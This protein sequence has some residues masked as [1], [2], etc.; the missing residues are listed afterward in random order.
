MK[1]LIVILLYF[2]SAQSLAAISW[3]RIIL[4]NG[5]YILMGF[6]PEDLK[7]A[8][9]LN[10]FIEG[11]GRPGV[12]LD[13]AQKIGGNSVYIGRPCQYFNLKTQNACSKEIWTSHRYSADVVD[14]MDRAI[15]VLKI[16]YKA[17]HVRLVGFSG[18]GAIASIIASKRSDV[19][20]L[21]TVAGNL[22]HK[23]WTDFNHSPPL[24]GSLNPIDFTAKLKNVPQ[25]HLIGD[26]DD[27]VPS[28]VLTSYLARLKQLDNVHIYVVPGADHTCCWSV[29]LA[30]VLV[31]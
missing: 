4:S 29:A 7:D 25:I 21:V 1:M 17:S 16:R 19:A 30:D 15:T 5:P 26:K 12:A 9:T 11:D 31:R 13:L 28:S 20:L 23:S 6:A 18:G 10:V 14:S 27:I 3:N 22:D 8:D 24:S 2:Y